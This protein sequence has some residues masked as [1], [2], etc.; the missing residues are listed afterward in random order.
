MTKPVTKAGKVIV[1]TGASRGIGRA[2]AERVSS[3]GA[4]LLL[5]Y[6]SNDASAAEV[7][8]SCR[9]RGAEVVL[10]AGDLSQPEVPE[11]LRDAALE[12]FGSVDVLINNAAVVHEDLLATL[13][14]Q[15]LDAMVAINIVALTR[16]TRAFVRP[17]L[18]KRNGSIINISSS[19]ASR[20]SRGNAVYAGT[21]GY[22]EAFTR[23]MA[24]E[25]GSK[26]I[27]VNA[28][29]PGITETDMSNAVRALA[30]DEIKKG[31]PLR[32]FGQPAEIANVVAFLASDE[33]AYI[34]GEVIGAHGGAG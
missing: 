28:V 13:T 14:D 9:E 24:V 1:I 23:A 27:R 25:L 5:C 29:A 32:R 30:G 6:R 33:A 19:L 22:V 34:T 18:R 7:E 4:R 16:L 8:K 11:Q 3:D 15:D 31:I 2:I 10:F 21:K 26:N 12:H 20:P 17:M